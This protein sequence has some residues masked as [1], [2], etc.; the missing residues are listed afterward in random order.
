MREYHNWSLSNV[1]DVIKAV[2]SRNEGRIIV[3]IAGP[4]AAGKSSIAKDICTYINSGATEIMAQECPLDGFHLNNNELEK[5]GMLEIKGKME[6]FDVDS[7]VSYMRRLHMGEG[8]FF[9][10][11]YS[12]EK[13]DVI[14]E[15]IYILS[16]AKVFVTEGNYIFS[17]IGQWAEL[18]EL[19]DL[20][21]FV[22]ADE[23]TITRRLYARH[24][25]GGMGEQESRKKV[26]ETDLP[27]ALIIEQ[28]RVFADVVL[29][30]RL[31]GDFERFHRD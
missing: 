15:G 14:K 13:H 23:A 22:R 17:E 30:D 11:I 12:R 19:F 4:P 10:P 20:R 27:N 3:G 16:S 28:T 6:T 2:S 5:N 8:E 25:R 7:Y 21:I 24:I 18:A 1:V 26:A 31:K 9:W 29:C